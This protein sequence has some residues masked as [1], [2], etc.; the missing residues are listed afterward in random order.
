MT[1][2]G[3]Q[4]ETIVTTFAWDDVIEDLYTSWRDEVRRAGYAH[5]VLERRLR[6]RWIGVGLVVV[7]AAACAG[8]FALAPLV[9]PGAYARAT[10]GIDPDVMP[11]AVA[12][13]AAVAA[14]F[15]MLQAVAPSAV[16]AERHRT[17]AFRYRSLD[18]AMAATLAL[19]RETRP[20]PDAAL[21]WVRERLTRY[22][23]Q[24]PAVAPRRRA[25]LEASFEASSAS[26]DPTSLRPV[27]PDT[28]SLAA[29]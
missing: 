16:R 20:S 4:L 5:E 1:E 12:S 19:P 21:A 13:L 28:R 8:A 7:V 17:A 23:R 29:T 11:I 15:A 18:R 2:S 10:R 3:M 14:V 26:V 22:E 25:K 24:S 27:V 9:A 6:L